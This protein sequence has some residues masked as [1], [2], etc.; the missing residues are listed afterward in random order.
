MCFPPV[1]GSTP[2]QAARST[3]IE[4][5]SVSVLVA[6]VKSLRILRFYQNSSRQAT[7]NPNA[8]PE[9][10]RHVRDPAPANRN[11]LGDRR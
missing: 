10:T 11:D 4:R 3:P 6:A 7:D 8:R 2:E 9:D 1:D 5:H